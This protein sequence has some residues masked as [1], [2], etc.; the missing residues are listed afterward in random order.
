MPEIESRKN[1][2][3][4]LQETD[5]P[6]TSKYSLR[7]RQ[8]VD[9]NEGRKSKGSCSSKEKMPN[10]KN[11]G[12]NTRMEADVFED[13]DTSSFE[14]SF[15]EKYNKMND[16]LKWKLQCTGRV[17]EDVLYNSI[18]NFTSEHLVHS[19]TIDVNDPMLEEVFSPAELEEMDMTNTK[20]DPELSAD[21]YSHLARYYDKTSVKEIRELLKDADFSGS[22]FEIETLTYSIYSLI[23]QYERNP[24]AFSLDHYEAWYNV[25]VWGPIIDRTYDDIAHIDVI[26][27]ESSSLASSERRNNNRTLDTRKEMGRRGDAIIRKCSSGLKLEF[28]G[29]EAG[30]HYEGQNATKWLKESG[31]KL[32][33]M[34]RDMFVGLCKH[35]NWDMGKMN[36]IET[37]GYIHGGSVLMIMSLDLPAGY[38]TRITKSDL[39]HI[40][41]EIGSFSEAIKLITA[42]RV[43]RTMRLLHHTETETDDDVVSILKNASSLKKS[44]LLEHFYV[45]DL[46]YGWLHSSGIGPHGFVCRKC[47]KKKPNSFGLRF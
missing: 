7:E 5:E 14:K 30:R 10:K 27:G 39:Y 25:N 31:L 44:S 9:Y 18:K 13:V 20:E 26:R 12:K 2:E 41:E 24:N 15:E 32:P 37:I 29:S 36:K 33:K 19:F 6:T 34:M 3:T 46:I 42:M 1:D 17:V 43:T 8:V 35:T 16:D 22:S 21:L 40:P 4:D 28:G 11:S 45:Y 47:E 38:I 23:R